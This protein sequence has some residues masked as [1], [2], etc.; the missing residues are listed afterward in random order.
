MKPINILNNNKNSKGHLRF[1]LP[2]CDLLKF[3]ILLCRLLKKVKFAI[4]IN[5]FSYQYQN[6]LYRI[7][8]SKDYYEVLGVTKLPSVSEL[9]KAYRKL[10]LQFHPDKNQAPGATDAFKSNHTIFF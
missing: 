5:S 2:S 10:A 9:K 8:K 6:F 4:S 3:I 7:K 1:Q